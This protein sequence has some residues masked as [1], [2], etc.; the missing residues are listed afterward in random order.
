MEKNT[1]VI[2]VGVIVLIILGVG[3]YLY[4]QKSAV[5]P[6]SGASV[7]EPTAPTDGGAAA[8]IT[9][10]TKTEAPKNVKI[11]ELGEKPAEGVAAPISVA[12]AAPGVSAKLRRFE[13]KAENGVYNPSTIIVKKGDSIDIKF[14]AVDKTYDFT[15]P[16]YGIKAV[17]QKGETKLL[18]FQ[19]VNDG[20]FTYYCSVCGGLNSKTKG[21]IIVSP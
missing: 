11:P 20:K 19:A 8:P 10:P 17:A 21:Y 7:T 3:I 12:P 5:A 15:L 2:V 13:I 4:Q 6:P 14:T 18:G 16:D 9:S 1:K